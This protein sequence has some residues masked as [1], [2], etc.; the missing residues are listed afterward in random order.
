MF[1]LIISIGFL[2]N[3]GFSIHAAPK[4]A[5]PDRKESHPLAGEL[6]HPDGFAGNAPCFQFPHRFLDVVHLKGQVAQP[7]G[8]GVA[9]TLGASGNAEEFQPRNRPV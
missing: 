7:A 4:E 3:Q 9:Q 5:C 8:F 6:V 2:Q 1:A